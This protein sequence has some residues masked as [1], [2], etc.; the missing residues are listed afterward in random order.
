MLIE[1]GKGLLETGPPW[2]NRVSSGDSGAAGPRCLGWAAAR[3]KRTGN[4]IR[5]DHRAGRRAAGR[6]SW[7]PR[8]SIIRCNCFQADKRLKMTADCAA[9]TS[10]PE[11]R[12]K[13]KSPPPA[14]RD[15]ARR[16]AIAR[17][18]TR[19]F[20][21]RQPAAFPGRADLV[22]QRLRLPPVVL[23]NGRAIRSLAMRGLR[24]RW[25]PVLEYPTSP[26]VL[27]LPLSQIRWWR[28]AVC[29]DCRAG[30]LPLA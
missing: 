20:V 7:C 27:I 18:R 24:A 22:I 12:P 6:A 9:K 13:W 2:A 19:S 26:R 21:I 30:G 1:L 17:L 11:V 23:A 4:A 28:V 29:R 3:W 15:G 5:G 8:R 25:L 10:N 16:G 14:Q